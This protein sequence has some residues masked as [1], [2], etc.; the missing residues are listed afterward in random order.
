VI[1]E[2]K[3]GEI[4]GGDA[5]KCPACGA[6]NEHHDPASTYPRF[7]LAIILALAM[8]VPLKWDIPWYVPTIGFVLAVW[9]LGRKGGW[10]FGKR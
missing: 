8:Y 10:R 2:C 9:F 4:V 3:C 7:A 6:T 5:A 1:N